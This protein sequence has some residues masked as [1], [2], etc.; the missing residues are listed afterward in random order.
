MEEVKGRLC[1][2]FNRGAKIP[3][4]VRAEIHQEDCPHMDD[5]QVAE[6]ELLDHLACLQ[7]GGEDWVCPHAEEISY[8]VGEGTYICKC[9]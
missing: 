5:P 9:K 6:E 1:F 3:F 2:G 4:S 8:N 7:L